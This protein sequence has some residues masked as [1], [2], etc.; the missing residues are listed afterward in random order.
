MALRNLL[1]I[2][3][4]H[5]LDMETNKPLSRR[6]ISPAADI[7]F[8]K[9]WR[10][11]IQ[12]TPHSSPWLLEKTYVHIGKLFFPC[13]YTMFFKSLYFPATPLI[14]LVQSHFE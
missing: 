2:Y 8:D 11:P 14:Q 4:F 3:S 13:I 7:N 1:Q 9:T 5:D 12:L 10:L 6:H